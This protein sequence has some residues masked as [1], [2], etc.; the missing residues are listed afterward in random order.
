MALENR[1]VDCI[2]KLGGSAITSKQHL[3]KANTQAINIAA[4][5]VHEMTR[6]C[7]IVHGAGSFGHF[8]AKKYNIATGFNDTDFEQQRIGFS[9]T[10]LSVTKLN[11]II[12]QALIEKDVPAVSISPCGLW[13]TTDRSVT[14]TFLQPINDLL[15]A[16]FVPVVHGDAVI[17]TSLGCTI[18]SG[19]TIIQILAENLC[20]KRIIFITDTNGIYDRPPH[21]DDAKLLRY[22]SVTKDGKVTNEIETSQLEHDVTGG[23]QTKI[24]SA[25]HIVS[26][27]NIPVHVVKLGSAAAWKLLDKGELEESDI[28]T[29]ITLQESEYPK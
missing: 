21:N 9:Q 18:L 22:I 24:A 20:P 28:A 15:R 17:D 3:E 29:T 8:H 13:K 10:R 14:S 7:V 1:H 4:S 26:K 6:K 19:D 27:C 2:I 16:G 11:H 23:V 5:H 25:A 12:V